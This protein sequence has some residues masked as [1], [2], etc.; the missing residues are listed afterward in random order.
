M[1]DNKKMHLVK[2][3]K[4][5]FDQRNSAFTGGAAKRSRVKVNFKKISLK[6]FTFFISNRFILSI[7][8]LLYKYININNKNNNLSGQTYFFYL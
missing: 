3:R 7:F 6:V 8:N 4:A 5:M 2:V 1:I